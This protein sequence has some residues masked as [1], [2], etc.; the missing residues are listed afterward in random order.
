MADNDD[1][2]IKRVLNDPNREAKHFVPESGAALYPLMGYT[3]ATISANGALLSIEF[4]VP[5]PES[6]SRLLRLGMTRAQCTELGDALKRPS[7][8]MGAI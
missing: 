6:G 7:C 3:T 4:L 2:W 5:P 8:L 1:E